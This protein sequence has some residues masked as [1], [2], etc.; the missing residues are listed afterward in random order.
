VRRT[1]ERIGRV[2]RD[3]R[4]FVTTL[5]ESSNA[6]RAIESFMVSLF[7]KIR[8]STVLFI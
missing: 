2:V 5:R 1:P 3:D 8:S 6:P 4:A 7:Y